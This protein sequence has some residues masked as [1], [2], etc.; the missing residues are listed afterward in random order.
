[1]YLS[2]ELGLPALKVCISITVVTV[3][4][5]SYIFPAAVRC[6]GTG[7]IK[8]DKGTQNRSNFVIN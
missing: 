4:I 2:P 5:H 3:P 8:V 6:T 1:M 7:S